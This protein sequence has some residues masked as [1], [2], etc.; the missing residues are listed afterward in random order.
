[1]DNRLGFRH[2]VFA[3][4]SKIA[5]ADLALQTSIELLP[6]LEEYLDV[7]FTMQKIDLFAIP[8]FKSGG[9]PSAAYNESLSFE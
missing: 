2:R 9:I 4:S 5:N 7:N 6:A 1:M 8:N 3:Q